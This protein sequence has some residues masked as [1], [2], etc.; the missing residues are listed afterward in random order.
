VRR[1]V[2]SNSSSG[3][4][5]SDEL[6]MINPAVFEACC[7]ILEKLLLPNEGDVYLDGLHGSNT[8]TSNFTNTRTNKDA[9]DGDSGLLRGTEKTP[10]F[11]FVNSGIA[12]AGN[13]N[14]N[15]NS[16]SSSDAVITPLEWELISTCDLYKVGNLPL[17]PPEPID[18]FLQ[19]KD[20]DEGGGGGGGGGMRGSKQAGKL[21]RER[22]KKIRSDNVSYA[23]FISCA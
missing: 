15:G 13:A 3:N 18:A 12:S 7:S 8:N 6:I 20:D 17:S 23:I 2:A 19:D 22:K 5:N 11:D 4:K 10:A 1:N 14:S 9:A 21:H 16:N